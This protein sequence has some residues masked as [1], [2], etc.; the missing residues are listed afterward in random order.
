MDLRDYDCLNDEEDCTGVDPG[1]T[2]VEPGVAVCPCVGQ[3]EAHRN[4]ECGMSAGSNATGG[5]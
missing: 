3:M 1:V 5:R 2:V 4:A